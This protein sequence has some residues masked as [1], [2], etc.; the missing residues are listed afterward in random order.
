MKKIWSTIQASIL[1][2]C[3]CCYPSPANEGEN[4]ELQVLPQGTIICQPPAAPGPIGCPEEGFSIGNDSGSSVID[5]LDALWRNAPHPINGSTAPPP[6]KTKRY[7]QTV[8]LLD[9]FNITYEVIK[10][11]FEGLSYLSRHWSEV[12]RYYYRVRSFVNEDSDKYFRYAGGSSIAHD[13]DFNAVKVVVDSLMKEWEKLQELLSEEEGNAERVIRLMTLDGGEE[14]A[15][16]RDF[17]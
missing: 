14:G 11:I 6:K 3:P 1:Y 9:E 13:A 7:R 8:A 10:S 4:I 15:L 17:L 2:C 16:P 5:S 12:M